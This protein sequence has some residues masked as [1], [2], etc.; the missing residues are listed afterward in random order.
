MNCS[1]DADADQREMT[2]ANVATAKMRKERKYGVC[3][4]KERE[5]EKKPK[6]RPTANKGQPAPFSYF[7]FLV[8]CPGKGVT[9]SLFPFGVG[10]LLLF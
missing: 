10:I 7:S 3:S 8:V 5:R 9:F 6:E 2:G 1:G 4:S